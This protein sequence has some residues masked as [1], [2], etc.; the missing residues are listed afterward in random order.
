MGESLWFDIGHIIALGY[1]DARST[2]ACSDVLKEKFAN[3]FE[4]LITVED[5]TDQAK[6]AKAQPNL[7]PPNQAYRCEYLANFTLLWRNTNWPIS[8]LRN[9]SSIEWWVSASINIA[10]RKSRASTLEGRGLDQIP[11]ALSISERPA[12]VEVRAVPE[13]WEGDLICGPKNS[14]IATLVE[15]HSCYVMLAKVEDSKS[16][17]VIAALI[18]QAQML[19]SKL[20]KSL[21]WDRGREIKDHR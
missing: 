7:C 3:D 17:T 10:V 20:Y 9:V 18:K 12:S 4:N 8:S 1:A 21:T 5:N 16:S 19:P 13:H 2:A 14:Y 6:D 15:R 11:E